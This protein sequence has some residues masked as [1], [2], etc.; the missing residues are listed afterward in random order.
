[1]N[2]IAIALK[3]IETARRTNIT[4]KM[5]AKTAAYDWPACSRVSGTQDDA[6]DILGTGDILDPGGILDPDGSAV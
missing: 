4:T 2:R 6:G 1:M 3:V 5:E